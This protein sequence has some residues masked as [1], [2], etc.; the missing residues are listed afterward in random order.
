[1]K[2]LNNYETSSVITQAKSPN[3]N[4]LCEIVFRSVHS[5]YCM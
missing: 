1:M 2:K 4:G 3:D 5:P